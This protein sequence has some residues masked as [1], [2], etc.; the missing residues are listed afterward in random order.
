MTV[1]RIPS[2]PKDVGILKDVLTSAIAATGSKTTEFS[3]SL[4][5]EKANGYV[6]LVVD[7]LGTNNLEAYLGHAPRIAKLWSNRKKSIRCEFPSTTVVSLA[8]LSTGLRSAE[9]GLLGYNIANDSRTSLVN[10]LSGWETSGADPMIYRSAETLSERTNIHVVSQTTYQRSGFTSLTMPRA[11]FHG[12]DDLQERFEAA[13]RIASAE[14]GVVYLY[15]PELDQVGHRFGF[16][17]QQWLSVLE[18]IDS[19]SSVLTRMTKAKALLTAD[20]GMVNVSVDNQIHLDAL[21]SL[22]G[23]DLIAGGDTRSSF[24]YLRGTEQPDV[25]RLGQAIEAELGPEVWVS[26]WGELASAGWVASTPPVR[27]VPDLILLARGAVTLYDRRTC[28]PRSL[29]MLGHHGSITDAE[30]QV[31]LLFL[32]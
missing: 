8:M 23:I 32:N 3:N 7:G 25:V 30:T 13:A 29:E 21:S 28:K 12:V 1:T 16:G 4:K 5:F 31:P 27:Q 15:V 26:T 18:D 22:Q 17:T 10:L 9:H 2:A 20:H 19:A 11:R 6:V 14:G 24:I